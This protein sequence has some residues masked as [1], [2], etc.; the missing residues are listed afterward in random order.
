MSMVEPGSAGAGLVARVRAI[1][2]Q[3]GATWDVIDGEPATIGGLYRGYIL[4]LA[5]IPA[6][7][8][9]I[10]QL[11]FGVRAG[12]GGFGIVARPNPVWAVGGAAVSFGLG[13]LFVYVMA[14]VIEGLAPNFGAEKNRIQAM[15]LA[16]Y[17]PTASYVAGVLSLVAG[18]GVVG[19]LVGLI[20][21]AAFVYSLYTLYQGL[22]KLMKNAPERTVG[23][24]VTV[25][26]VTFV[27]GL[28]VS[29]A[30]SA[31]SMAT[32]RLA[33]PP[34]VSGKVTIPGQGEL[35][36][37]ELQ[38]QAEAAARQIEAGKTVTATDTDALKGYLP[39][40]LGGYTRGE[41]SASSSEAAGIQGSQ[42][43]ARY[44]KGDSAIRVQIT[45]IGGA[46][47][48]AGMMGAFKMKSSKESATG[49]EKYGNVG[50]RMTHE[51]Y[52]RASKHGEYG[53]LVGERFMVE[54]KGDGASMDELKDAVDAVGLPRLEAQAKAR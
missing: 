31:V 18:W 8:G 48:I 46:G 44:E 43:E 50:G 32:M 3:P 26:V 20:L 21:I 13:L 33:G 5:A 51:S 4:P 49:Y 38:K 34:Q 29:M 37:G 6:I 22:P 15:K 35:D 42:V 17:F 9:L 16:A 27:L 54:A 47:A 45:D 12:F 36:V 19:F 23:Y 7:A 39:A 2:T 14:L 53:V 41:V 25:L 28:I 52:D 1:L 10:G 40:S 24:F 30:Y 11:V